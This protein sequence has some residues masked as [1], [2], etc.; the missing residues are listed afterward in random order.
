MSTILITMLIASTTFASGFA[1]CTATCLISFPGNELGG[2]KTNV[3]SAGNSKPEALL[4]LSQK[5]D[6]LTVASKKTWGFTDRT[7]GQLITS[8]DGS[9]GGSWQGTGRYIKL[10]FN[11]SAA[12]AE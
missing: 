11:V 5:C 4:K 12:C 3:T 9:P 1:V 2:L 7:T 6:E 8:F 10:D